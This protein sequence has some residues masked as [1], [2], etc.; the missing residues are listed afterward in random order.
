[1]TRPARRRAAL[2]EAP[3]HRSLRAADMA[4][5]RGMIITAITGITTE[6]PP[7]SLP[8]LQTVSSAAHIQSKNV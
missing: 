4:A 8:T 2:R 1:M 6:A 3:L 5:R 7:V